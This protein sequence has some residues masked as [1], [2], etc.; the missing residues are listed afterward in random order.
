MVDEFAQ[1][2]TGD[3][4]MVVR[5]RRVAG[6]DRPPA[7]PAIFQACAGHFQLPDQLRAQ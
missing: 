1:E 6:G 5:L 4:M 3:M 7:L 2:S